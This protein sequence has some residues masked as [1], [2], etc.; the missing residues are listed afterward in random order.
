MDDI[1]NSQGSPQ[2]LPKHQG[3]YNDVSGFAATD[4]CE[5][6]VSSDAR[7]EFSFYTKLVLCLV[8]GLHLQL[9]VVNLRNVFMRLFSFYKEAYVFLPA[10]FCCMLF[11]CVA[12]V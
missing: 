10:E 4:E 1:N 5:D 7:C 9:I 2:L 6:D 11:W 12:R 8:S 3:P